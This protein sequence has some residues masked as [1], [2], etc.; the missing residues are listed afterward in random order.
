MS[1]CLA[2]H[3]LS[4]M[5]C[6]CTIWAVFFLIFI[7]ISSAHY[8][9]RRT[10]AYCLLD[11]RMG[12]VAFFAEIKE[13]C[14]VFSHPWLESKNSPRTF[15]SSGSTGLNETSILSVPL[16]SSDHS[17]MK[18]LFPEDEIPANSFVRISSCYWNTGKSTSNLILLETNLPHTVSL[19]LEKIYS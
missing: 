16:L 14:F 18:Y 8:F 2:G 5:T 12:E 9:F 11:N 4:L 1:Q 19:I 7:W 10:V 3:Y 17:L 15:S 13:K 6:Q